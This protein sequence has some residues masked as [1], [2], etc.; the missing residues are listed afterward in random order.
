M[1]TT[2]STHP[3]QHVPL[4][5][6]TACFIRCMPEMTWESPGP[7]ISRNHPAVVLSHVCHDWRQLALQIPQLWSK[8]RI[9]ISGSEK[10]DE[11]IQDRCMH[12]DN[13][14]EPVEVWQELSVQWPLS[15]VLEVGCAMFDGAAKS[16][17]LL[18]YLRVLLSIRRSSDRWRSFD[19][20]I[21]GTTFTTDP[22]YYI[23]GRGDSVLPIPESLP[24]TVDDQSDDRPLSI[25]VFC[26]AMLESGL[27][28]SPS[29]RH[30][31]HGVLHE[32]PSTKTQHD[33]PITAPHLTTL[34]LRGAPMG[35]AFVRSLHLP[36]LRSLCLVSSYIKF[37]FNPDG[38]SLVQD[39]MVGGAVELIGKVGPQ[40]TQLAISHE[41]LP[42]PSLLPCLEKVQ[43]L[44]WLSLIG[45]SLPRP[46]MYWPN[47]F[48]IGEEFISEDGAD[49]QGGN[50]TLENQAPGEEALEDE[51]PEDNV[52]E[53]E[54][55]EDEDEVPEN[56]AG[57]KTMGRLDTTVRTATRNPRDPAL[58][59]RTNSRKL[60]IGPAATQ[61]QISN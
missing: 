20:T 50:D 9:W 52:S 27:F 47:D 19:M 54:A 7:A 26:R 33:P 6:L 40:L 37:S 44:E 53:D 16:A 46:D 61:R 29:L 24:L 58:K 42:L 15:L 8:V 35:P 2:D 60:A 48:D 17:A 22:F 25:N 39:E 41:I 5:I 4:E 1:A 3:I 43:N 31:G 28:S 57:S 11:D 23:F 49:E 38:S 10:F 14:K 32:D 12:V 55:P 56:A 59:G 45:E 21:A 30:F 18:V 51:A 36:S 34:S 13:V